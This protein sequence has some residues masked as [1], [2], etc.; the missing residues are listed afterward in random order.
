MSQDTNTPE[1]AMAPICEAIDAVLRGLTVRIDTYV[2]KYVETVVLKDGIETSRD[3]RL[4]RFD[5][6]DLLNGKYSADHFEGWDGYIQRGIKEFSVI[7]MSKFGNL[8][9]LVSDSDTFDED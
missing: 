5:I 2:I 9:A 8:K 1:G 4:M 7:D 3:K 6:D